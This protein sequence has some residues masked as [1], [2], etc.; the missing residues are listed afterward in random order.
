MRGFGRRAEA[1]LD[2]SGLTDCGMLKAAGRSVECAGHNAR[3]LELFRRTPRGAHVVHDGSRQTRA[4][5]CSAQRVVVRIFAGRSAS[6]GRAAGTVHS[7]AREEAVSGGG[8]R[9]FGRNA[10]D[11]AG[12]GKRAAV[13][14]DVDETRR[15]LPRVPE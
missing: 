11:S 6:G 5:R 2:D 12:A 8:G 9:R 15:L 7:L 13:A 14:A 3:R 10:G 1:G 4:A